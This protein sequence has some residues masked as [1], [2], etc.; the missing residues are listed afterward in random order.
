MLIVCLRLAVCRCRLGALA[1]PLLFG[2]AMTVAVSWFIA[3]AYGGVGGKTK[4][5]PIGLTLRRD[6]DAQWM[7][8][9]PPDWID[10]PLY[11][12]RLSR[13]GA[14]RVLANGHK[15][16]ERAGRP[17]AHGDSS[18]FSYRGVVLEWTF[19]SGLP[20]IALRYS[21]QWS[22][23]GRSLSGGLELRDSASADPFAPSPWI[24]PC[25]IV[26]L[27]F[28]GNVAVYGVAWWV[29]RALTCACRRR[30]RAGRGLCAHCGHVLLSSSIRCPECG[31]E[32][33]RL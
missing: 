11:V 2:V 7:S 13:F 10:R 19:G 14:I 32:D 22:T 5:G 1:L 21:Q 27:G 12:Q 18:E 15:K 25:T 23:E 20:F 30:W 29:V 31:R 4:G 8:Q 6:P 9:P 16:F 3:Y 24:M 33:A 17:P 26:P 28:I